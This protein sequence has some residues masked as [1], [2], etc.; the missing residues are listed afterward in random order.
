MYLFALIGG[1]TADYIPSVEVNNQ[2]LRS[3]MNYGI[4]SLRFY[5]APL[6]TLYLIKFYAAVMFGPGSQGWQGWWSVI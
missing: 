6:T 5:T 2:V 4:L 3:K 1:Q